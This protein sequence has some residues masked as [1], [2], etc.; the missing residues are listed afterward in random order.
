MAAVSSCGGQ[1]TVDSPQ[2]L[3]RYKRRK[4]TLPLFFVGIL[5]GLSLKFVYDN[6]PMLTY[7]ARGFKFS[8]GDRERPVDQVSFSEND[9][10]ILDAQKARQNVDRRIEQLSVIF[11][12]NPQEFE[13]ILRIIEEASVKGDKDVLYKYDLDDCSLMKASVTCTKDLRESMFPIY[14]DKL[15]ELGFHVLAGIIFD[16]R[17]IYIDW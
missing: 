14:V 5:L 2:T 11:K 17:T 12:E 10:A 9:S 1:E 13:L 16:T 8:F 4:I 6:P 3:L 7:G 15:A